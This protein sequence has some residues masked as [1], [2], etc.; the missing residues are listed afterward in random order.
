MGRRGGWSGRGRRPAPSATAD[1]VQ[2]R[3][4]GEPAAAARR[5]GRKASQYAPGPQQNREQ[6]Q[7]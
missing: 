1:Q 6:E 2:S 4:R 7:A 5:S 3:G